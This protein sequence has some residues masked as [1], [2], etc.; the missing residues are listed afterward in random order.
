MGVHSFED[1]AKKAK[2]VYH[3][4][5]I[6]LVN[7]E[8]VDEYMELISCMMMHIIVILYWLEAKTLSEMM[9]SLPFSVR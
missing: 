7:T 4:N 9:V 2:A 5:R 3:V 8:K 6:V 1:L